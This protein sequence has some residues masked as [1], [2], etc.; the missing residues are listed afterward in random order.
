MLASSTS[1]SS[2]FFMS[3]SPSSR[4]PSMAGHVSPMGLR[5]QSANAP[6]SIDLA[7]GLLQMVQE[8]PPQLRRM[9]LFCHLRQG[10]QN[11]LLRLVDVL[12]QAELLGLPGR[13]PRISRPARV[14]AS[15]IAIES[16][17]FVPPRVGC[18]RARRGPY[19]CHSCG[20]IVLGRHNPAKAAPHWGAS[21]ALCR[22]DRWGQ[23][24][25]NAKPSSASVRAGTEICLPLA[26][27]IHFCCT[28]RER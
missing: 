1:G 19:L 13:A 7:L 10:L 11:L 28:P 23:L 18:G 9:G 27:P 26:N 20:S 2:A 4:I 5:L 16:Q 14:Y 8:R 25:D 3:F 22:E 6:H 17:P 12:E 15:L 21:L 24:H